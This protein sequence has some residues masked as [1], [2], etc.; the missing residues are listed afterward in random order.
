MMTGEKK[1]ITPEPEGDG[2][3]VFMED[4]TEEEYQDYL[5]KEKHGWKNF[6]KTIWGKISGGGD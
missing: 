4:M 5:H 6:Y 1:E 2:K 3:A